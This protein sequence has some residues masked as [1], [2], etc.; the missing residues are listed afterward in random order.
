MQ[1]ATRWLAVVALLAAACSSP[2]ERLAH[3][4]ERGEA[5]LRDNEVDASLLEFQS[6]LKI[7]PQNAD[8]YER[9]GDVLM[10][11]SQLYP[12]AISYYRESHRLEPTRIHSIVREARLLAL[13][14][15]ERARELLDEAIS[16][17]PESAEVLRAQANFALIANDL[18]SKS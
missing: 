15:R 2:E 3:H 18:V 8:L 6:A 9:I 4:V 13:E 5:F 10:E 17:D 11:Y 1:R 7:Q 12:R 14:D 16:Q